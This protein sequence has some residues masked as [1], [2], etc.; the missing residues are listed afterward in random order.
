MLS[1]FVRTFSTW[2]HHPRGWDLRFL[3]EAISKKY[4]AA[5]ARKRLLQPPIDTNN[6]TVL[7]DQEFCKSIAQVRQHTLLDVGRLANLW[8]LARQVGPGIFLE[9]GSYRGGSALHICNAIDGQARMF[10][11]FDPFEKGGFEKITDRDTLFQASDFQDAA[12]A[13]VVHLLSCKPNAKVIQGFFPA[14]AESLAL[15]NI[16]FCH[17]EVDV[18]AATKLSLDYLS[19]R[20]APRSLIVLDDINRNVEGVDTAVAE[21]L[22][23]HPSFIFIPVFPSQGVLLSKIL[24]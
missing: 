7:S 18:Y 16:A 15:S 1:R 8:C 9:V 3:S 19:S 4:R 21:F 14:A 10:Y 23:D 22:A 12:Y 5:K 6:V 11:C 17:L 24:W 13:A 20:M 2:R